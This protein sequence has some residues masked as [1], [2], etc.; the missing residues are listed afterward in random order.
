MRDPMRE[1][2]RPVD[3]PKRAQ[4][5]NNR[6]SARSAGKRGQGFSSRTLSQIGRRDP[7]DTPTHPGVTRRQR[8]ARNSIGE[9]WR[10][11]MAMR[12]ER[13]K[14]DGERD[15]RLRFMRGTGLVH[16]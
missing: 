1:Y 11:R 13:I 16:D 3:A 9:S 6:R 4:Y 12:S 8:Q 15:L 7:F 2:S 14:Y 5:I 10:N